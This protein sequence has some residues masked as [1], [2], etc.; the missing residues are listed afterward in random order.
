MK[1]FRLYFAAAISCMIMTAAI[2]GIF[3]AENNTRTVVFG[4]EGAM[5]VV[6]LHDIEEILKTTDS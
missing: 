4:E 1:I 5:T 2:G 3:E 6:S